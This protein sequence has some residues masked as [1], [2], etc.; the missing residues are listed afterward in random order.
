M[1]VLLEDEISV[2]LLI[3]GNRWNQGTI[4]LLEARLH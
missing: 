2:I 4:G 1:T 3:N